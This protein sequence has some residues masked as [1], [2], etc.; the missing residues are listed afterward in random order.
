MSAFSSLHPSIVSALAKLGIG[1]PTGAQAS[2]IPVV[3]AGKNALLVAP[4]GIGKT[5][6]AMLPLLDRILRGEPKGIH[7]LYVTPLRALNRDMLRRMEFFGKELGISVA[8]RHGDTPQGERLKQAR[9]P[10]QVMITTPETLQIMFTG[11]KLREA[12]ANVRTVVVDEIHELAGDERGAQLSVGLERLADV[13]GDFQRI[14]LSATVGSPKEVASY[15]GG[16]GR[17]VSIVKAAIPKGLTISVELPEVGNT[18]RQL[19]EKLQTE[20]EIAAAMRRCRAAIEAHRS[21]LFFVNTRDT[22]EYLASRFRLWDES[23]AVGVHHGSLSRHVRVEMEEAFKA[24]RLR[25][26]IC[27]SSLELGIDV[28]SAD[29]VIQYGSP[30]E[31]AR[32]VQRVG[33]AGHGVDRTSE[34]LIIA[35]GVDDIAEGSVI[36]RQAL[37]GE[38]ED[39]RIRP[40]PLAVLANQIVAHAM[41][42]A[43]GDPDALFEAVRRTWA[44]RSL[45]RAV[46]DRVAS[47]LGDVRT[48]SVRDGRLRKSA[49]TLEHYFENISMIPDEK[50][51][52]VIDI[53]TRR[54]V[55]QLDEAFVAS[56]TD[57][58]VPFI[59]KG[60][61]WRIVDIEGDRILVEQVPQVGVVPSWVGEE[62]PVP[63]GVAKEVGEVRRTRQLQRYPMDGP[64][65]RSLSEKLGEQDAK[66]L[67]MADDET[68]VVETDGGLMV[69]NACLGTKVNETLGR[70]LA[71]LMA[72]RSGE[73]VGMRVDPYRIVLE[74]PWKADAK[75]AVDILQNT[76]PDSLAPLVRLAVRRSAT[77]KWRF[78]Q[79]AKK[80]GVVSRDADYRTMNLD[81]LV[82][83]YDGSPLVEEA[84]ERTIW[85]EMDVGAACSVLSDIRS[86]RLKLSSGRLS[87]MGILGIEES[88]ELVAPSRPSKAILDALR[89]RL[90][91]EELRMLCLNCKKSWR[92][93]AGK[94]PEKVQCMFCGASQVAALGPREVEKARLFAKASLTANEMREIKRMA[95]SA[96]LIRE[97]GRRAALVLCGRG[98]GPDAAARIL[99]RPRSTDDELLAYVLEAEV[100]FAKTKRFWD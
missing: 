38:I 87:P 64:C 71:S 61:P 60:E 78:V 27:T 35:Q 93:R 70:M 66:K 94:L 11:K 3:S 89:K 13:A 26:L 41:T 5:E 76:S 92:S 57:D 17:D 88:G 16:A 80:F 23:F 100:T 37:A 31:V 2:M 85:E 65:R 1:R 39:V 62:I 9:D 53:A 51:F 44:F 75:A 25:A 58:R 72:A 55:G 67:A 48:I 99:Q 28:G 8:V 82:E 97:H 42:H 33:R 32:L 83:A 29:L 45:D 84:L 18:D 68:I 91:D 69:V 34:G 12:L 40:N 19:S 79:A 49:R 47:F 22:A 52:Q 20:P 7:V 43:T 36:A 21:T 24:E 6:A 86:G 46:F 15:L 56:F 54:H 4:T 96:D 90:E 98:V 74:F 95:K 30:R 77:F 14:G 50:T 59:V 10:P 73:G 63:I 81:A